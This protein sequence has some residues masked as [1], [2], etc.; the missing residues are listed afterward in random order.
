M[1]PDMRDET[2]DF[3]QE[4]TKKVSE[5]DSAPDLT[6]EEAEERMATADE[7]PFSDEEVAS[8]VSSAT[9][10]SPSH[11]R[12]LEPDPAPVHRNF[13]LRHSGALTKVAAL[14]LGIV[15][16]YSV[17][18]KVINQPDPTPTFDY[19]AETALLMD[20]QTETRRRG[21]AQIRVF[22]FASLGV[23]RLKAER[24]EGGELQGDAERYLNNLLQTLRSEE[25]LSDYQP[26]DDLVDLLHDTTVTLPQRR[27]WLMT[28]SD[29]VH[30]AILALKLPQTESALTS[31]RTR[32]LDMLAKELEN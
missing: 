1:S 8:T 14:F 12:V 29:Q 22:D 23:Q 24:E 26:V 20:P 32:T 30:N 25:T 17:M 15:M 5:S 18:G 7:A 13:F 28:L 10:E 16:L 3:W 9:D 19:G 21:V 11:L 2:D 27:V 6:M 31:G 4:L